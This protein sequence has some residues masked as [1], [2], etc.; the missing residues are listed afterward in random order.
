MPDLI[1]I[2]DGVFQKL[3][4]KMD[5]GKFY[6]FTFVRAVAGKYKGRQ[7]VSEF[8]HLTVAQLG[9]LVVRHRHRACRTLRRLE[10]TNSE[11]SALTAADHIFRCNFYAM[12]REELLGNTPDFRDGPFPL[13]EEAASQP[14]AGPG[15][16]DD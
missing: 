7:V 3:Q 12:R 11:S 15:G 2:P 13:V 14:T 16:R 10:I 5:S 6:R 1:K 4:R 8:D 9:E